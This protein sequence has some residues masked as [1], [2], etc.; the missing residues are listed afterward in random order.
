MESG[1]PVSGEPVEQGIALLRKG[2]ALNPNHPSLFYFGI[3]AYQYRSGDYEAALDA[4]MKID[5]L[6]Y[7][8]TQSFRAAIYGQLGRADEAQAAVKKLLELYPDYAE[9]A[10]REFNIWNF[11]Q[12]SIEHFAEGLAKAGLDIRTW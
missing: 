11:P 7:H 4:A 1:P 10:W 3:T 12:E 9:E 8:H 5:W 6:E 2:V